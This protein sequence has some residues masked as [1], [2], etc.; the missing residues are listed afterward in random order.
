MFSARLNLVCR[1][2]YLAIFSN[3]GNICHAIRS[4]SNFQAND[5]NNR[6]MWHSWNQKEK[7]YGLPDNRSNT[8]L[9]ISTKHIYS[10]CCPLFHSLTFIL[11]S[12][13]PSFL[14][15]FLALNNYSMLP[16]NKHQHYKVSPLLIV[17]ACRAR[18]L[19]ISFALSPCALRN[20]RS[21]KSL[22]NNKSK[23]ALTTKVEKLSIFKWKSK[24]LFF[25]WSFSFFYS[26][27]S[28]YICVYAVR[29]PYIAFTTRKNWKISTLNLVFCWINMK[30]MGNRSV[31][32]R[33]SSLVFYTNF[34][35]PS[36]Q[37]QRIWK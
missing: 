20:S 19:C 13:L 34:L 11:V 10:Q 37:W 17:F 32:E 15:W 8:T 3:D 12:I 23:V 35:S 28:T 5:S 1:H 2:W 22:S 31:Y 33:H 18:S 36:L 16:E 25:L 27:V 26:D 7:R 9:N 14:V 30:L 6:Q 24:Q 29:M 4:R 21:K